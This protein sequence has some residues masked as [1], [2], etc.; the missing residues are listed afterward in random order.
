M[1]RLAVLDMAHTTIDDH[2]QVYRVLREAA[3]RGGA[4]VS[5]EVFAQ[6]RGTEKRHAIGRLLSEGGVEVTDRLHEQ[7][8]QWFRAELHRTYSATPPAA[9]PG[10]D[11]ALSA[12][13]EMGVKVAL[14][15][16]FSREIADLILEGVGWRIGHELDGSAT[17]DEVEAGRPA[18][19]LIQRVMAETGITDPAE[20]IS[21]GDTEADVRSG[22]N[23]GGRS[24]G[25]LTGH[26]TRADF[27]ALGADHVLDSAAELPA[28]L[29]QLG[30]PRS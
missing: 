2:D 5:D 27:T 18:P 13:R 10:V 1:I 17:G 3:A 20:V 12:L 15:T 8:W 26:L 16:G 22:Q 23:A 19:F 24:V 29:A 28:L 7:C 11:H 14:N 30:A 4:E 6:H 25:V 21:A 9:L